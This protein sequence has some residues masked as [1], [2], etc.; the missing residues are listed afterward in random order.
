MSHSDRPPHDE[1]DDELE[2]AVRALRQEGDAPAPQA[3]LT[4]ERILVE[5]RPARRARRWVWAIPLAALLGGST[6]LAAT[7]RLPEVLSSVAHAFGL[8]PPESEATRTDPH[9][10]RTNVPVAPTSTAPSEDVAPSVPALSPAA[11]DGSATPAPES[12]VAAPAEHPEAVAARKSEG[13]PD[14]HPSGAEDPAAASSRTQAIARP[15]ASTQAP[16][17][18]PTPA[19][20]TQPAPEGPDALALYRA[21]HRL[22]FVEQNPAAALVAWDAYPANDPGG[23]LAIDA[24]YDRALCLLRLGRRDEARRALQPFAEGK[25]GAYRQSDAKAL[26]DALDAH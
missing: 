7:G 2:R 17:E 19:P 6:V 25:Y 1:Q 3:R 23:P 20:S 22:H 16:S 10:A 12:T 5:L 11:S 4:R 9:A 18:K 13:A 14:T 8:T 26:L 24:R 15:V 21:A